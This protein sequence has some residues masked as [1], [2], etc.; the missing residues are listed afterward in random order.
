MRTRC[1]RG[2]SGPVHAQVMPVPDQQPV[3]GQPVSGRHIGDL[4]R[5]HRKAA[6]MTQR[7]LATAAQLS[8]GSI[9]DLEQGRTAS[10]RW[11][12]I[13]ALETALDLSPEHRRGLRRMI[14]L[15]NHRGFPA[16]IGRA[17]IGRS[18]GVGIGI[19]GPIAATRSGRRVDLGPGRQRAILAMLALHPNQPVR[20]SE[21]IDLLWP[22]GP[23]K[24]AA[25]IVQ[26]YI[27]H[28]R[29]ALE[30]EL[31]VRSR[32]RF[33][34]WT[35]D[36]YLLRTGSEC[37]VDVELFHR[38]RQAGDA[39]LRS[40][41]LAAARQDY[42]DA[43][44]LCRGRTAADLGLL[45]E[46]PKVAETEA[47]WSEVI[48]RYCDL[49]LLP[50]WYGPDRHPPNIQFLTGHPPSGNLRDG[51]RKALDHL[52][53]LCA[54]QEFNEPAFAR[55]IT[56]MGN[57]GQSAAATVLFENLRLRLQQELGISPSGQVTEAYLGVIA[58]RRGRTQTLTR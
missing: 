2:A 22:A 56:L 17:A 57:T 42:D 49:A 26:G 43:I 4:I 51:Q 10:P 27:S 54:A 23:P 40:G 53:T 41:D 28:L 52:R 30:P 32:G 44:A 46:H 19:L 20:M 6:G 16:D 25:I 58:R 31:A 3:S 33:V 7:Q 15:G 38:L 24:S 55:L 36:G 48:L 37:R 1:E 5:T 11:T 34:A 39:A 14:K 18:R 45:R 21:L 47:A 50:D 8:L 12:A 13:E 35:G 29:R 9:R